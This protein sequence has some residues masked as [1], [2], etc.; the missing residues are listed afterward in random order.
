MIR[1]G[2]MFAARTLGLGYQYHLQS[3]RIFYQGQLKSY[4]EEDDSTVIIPNIFV[5]NIFLLLRNNKG[6]RRPQQRT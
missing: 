1:Q 2:E 6:H 5:A 3:S 4:V